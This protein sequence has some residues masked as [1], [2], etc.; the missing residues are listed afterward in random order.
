MFKAFIITKSKLTPLLFFYWLFLLLFAGGFTALSQTSLTSPN[1]YYPFK[2]YTTQNGLLNSTIQ[3]MAQDKQGYVW[4][5][6][7]L[8]ITRFNGKTFFHQAVPEIGSYSVNVTYMETAESG[9]I[10]IATEMRGI[11]VQ[12]DDGRFKQYLPDGPISAGLNTCIFLKTCPD[13]SILFS[14][15]RKLNCLKNDSITILYEKGEAGKFSTLEMDRDNNIWFGSNKGLGF[16]K[17]SDSGFEPVFLPEF[18]DMI[19]TKILFDNEGTLHVATAYGYFRV[20]WNQPFVYDENYIVE[21]P[22]QEIEDLYIHYIYLD[23]EQNLWILPNLYGFLRTKG[24]NITLHLTQEN[25]LLSSASLCMMQDMEGNYWFGTISGVSMIENFDTYAL[26]NDGKIFNEANGLLSDNYDR[27]WISS[28][29]GLHIYQ[30]DKLIPVSLKGTPFEIKGIEQID[31]YDSYLWILNLYALYRLPLTKAFPDLRKIEK[32]ADLSSFK[33][34]IIEYFRSDSI[35]IWI[36]SKNKLFL[37]NN[38]QVVPVTFNYAETSNM[39]PY[40]MLRDKYGYYWCG[41][42][43]NGLYRGIISQPQKN[44]VLFDKIKVYK[45]NVPDS[46]F[47]M[48]FIFDICFDKEDNLWITSYHTGVHKLVI[49]SSGV[50]SHK[51]Y[52]TA[53]GLSS[54]QI[55]VLSCDDEGRIWMSGVKGFDILR[56]DENGNEIIEHISNFG[57]GG[58][59]IQR[60]NKLMLLTLDGIFI[61]PNQI[62][63]EKSQNIPNVFITNLL[64]NGVADAGFSTN[65]NSIRL[66]HNQNNIAIEFSSITFKDS[67]KVMHQYKLD[68][69]TDDWSALSDR[70]FVEYASLRPGKYNFKVRAVIG[71]VAGEE[72]TLTFRIA[73]AFYQTIWFYLLIAI[74]VFS[75]LYAFYKYRIRQAV[76]MDRIRTRIASDLHDDIGS[77]LSSI[78]LLS[79]VAKNQDKEEMLAKA[80]SK[81]GDSSR[82]VLNSMDD[83]IWSVNPQNDCLS[84]LIIR[85]REY[86]IPICEAKDIELTMNVDEPINSLK[87]DMEERRNAYLI[88]KEAINNAVKHSGCKNLTVAFVNNHHLEIFVKDDGCGFDTTSSKTRNGLVNM[89]SRARHFGAELIIKSKINEGTFVLLK[90]KNHIC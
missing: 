36:A 5:G 48:K 45:Q 12:Q 19:I 10:A 67:D 63:N 37:Y 2:N 28:F 49:D 69:I 68:G 53:N 23:K 7:L 13:G 11:F 79:D 14:K 87:L 39:K 59:H 56:F 33:F 24:D 81:I 29:T 57:M 78:S 20:I 55:Q 38:R 17:P 42:C 66:T 22:F 76:K 9:N 89:E 77:T 44:M 31:I 3:T 88:V 84:N 27:I 80:L 46:S 71:G 43:N 64:I 40:S 1:E 35:G 54:N 62:F 52:S 83:I 65:S 6:S 50:V 70:G 16:L 47:S 8:G 32:V 90:A 58:V 85:L 25:G 4:F 51:L 34:E 26:A 61:M 18:E 41:D 60:G 86:A 75:L 30:D 72:T 21:A 73:P 82:S 15:G 74:A